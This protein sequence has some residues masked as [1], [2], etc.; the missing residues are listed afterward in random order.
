MT[1]RKSPGRWWHYAILA[2]VFIGGGIHWLIDPP[3]DHLGTYVFAIFCLAIAA[4]SGRTAWTLF[5][6][7][8][9]PRDRRS[10]FEQI[11]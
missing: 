2:V 1:E 4:S 5:Q 9:L 8:H 6:R 10:E 11:R 7:R 3:V